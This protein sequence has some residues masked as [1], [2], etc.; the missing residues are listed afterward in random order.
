MTRKSNA[1]HETT[2]PLRQMPR[3]AILVTAIA[4]VLVAIGWGLHDELRPHTIPATTTASSP[5]AQNSSHT[6]HELASLVETCERTSRLVLLGSRDPRG[7]SCVT[8]IRAGDIHGTMPQHTGD[9][10]GGPGTRLAT[11][12]LLDRL[13]FKKAAQDF[14]WHQSRLKVYLENEIVLNRLAADV[15]HQLAE[16]TRQ[17]Y[18][19]VTACTVW[20]NGLAPVGF[21]SDT[22]WPGYCLTRLDRAVTQKDLPSLQRWAGELASATFSLDDL[23][24]WLG[25]LTENQL[26]ALEFQRRCQ[27]LFERVDARQTPYEPQKTISY[28]PAGVLCVNGEENYYEVERQ[29][30]RLFSMPPDRINELLNNEHLTPGSL[31]VLPGLR[32]GFLKVQ[33]ALSSENRRTWEEAART[34]YQHAYL[35]NMLFR[36]ISTDTIDELYA[37]LKKFDAIHPR[38]TVPEMMGALM[39]RGHSFG[40]LGW[41]DRYQPQLLGAAARIDAGKTDVQALLA[42]HRWTHDFYQTP[43]N[44]GPTFTLGDALQQKKLDCVRATDMIGAVFR[45]AGRTRFGHVRWCGETTGHSVAAYLGVENGKAKT[46][47]ADGLMPADRLEV[48]PECY[49]HAH[50]WPPGMENNPSPY[51]VELYVRGLDSYVWAEGYIARG[52]NAGWLITAAIPYSSHRPES[53]ARK[54]FDGP[55]PE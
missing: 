3:K 11:L 25:F 50:A 31:W 36:A 18:K 42:A 2:K 39:Y 13:D 4:S 35:M 9:L 44:Y 43:Q 22:D 24:R 54:V 10:D 8:I 1:V 51:A 6:V 53:T 41:D 26:V 40:G 49:F 48:W 17:F 27:T 23:H 38:A 32:G 47:L 16:K 15:A 20:P 28:L 34:P 19:T 21:S 7:S 14:T 5:P 30:E 29:A 52:P 12:Y 55:Y 33:D 45:N 46:L 37:A